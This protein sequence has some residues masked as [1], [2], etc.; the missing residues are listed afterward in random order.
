MEDVVVDPVL[1]AEAEVPVVCKDVDVVDVD[2]VVCV[3]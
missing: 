3:D 1:C 2:P